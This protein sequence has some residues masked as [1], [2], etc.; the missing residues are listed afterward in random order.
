M[1]IQY[2]LDI[3]N[4]EEALNKVKLSDLRVEKVRVW[5]YYE[6]IKHIIEFKEKLSIKDPDK[7][8]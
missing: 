7:Q 1:E 5:E 6:K 3:K 8:K 4:I 2:D